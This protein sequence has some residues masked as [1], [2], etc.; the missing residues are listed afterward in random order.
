M[1]RRTLLA[2]LGLF[3]A[4]PGAHAQAQAPSIVV[5]IDLR[6]EMAAGR[7]DPM[8]DSVGLRGA[9][10][11][12]SWQRTLPAAAVPGSPGWY[13]LS[14]RLD[15]APAQP[16][17]YKFKIDRPDAA[18]DDGWENGRNRVFVVGA[19]PV[20]IERAFGTDPGA[21]P[22]QRTGTIERIAPRPSGFVAPREVQVWLPPG[23]G[24]DTARRYPV[25]YLHDG[26]NVFDHEAAGAEW[27]VDEAAERGVKGG[28]LAPMIIVAV[29]STGARVL[30]YTPSAVS[31]GGRQQ[32]GGAALYARYLA[33]ELKPLI[34]T[35]YATRPGREHTAVG[36]SSLGGLV[37]MWLLLHHAGTF[38]AGLVV[39]PSVWW[40]GGAILREVA[41]FARG[42]APR[43]W[44]DMGGRE[45][46]PAVQGAR[47]LRD[48]LVQRGWPAQYTEAPGEGHDEAAW[49][50]RVPAMLRF[51][52]PVG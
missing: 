11:P 39:S 36:G 9:V 33:E 20:R 12:L 13:E 29:A 25:L 3:G 45:G 46:G 35:R 49:A 5:R 48:A 15:S 18:P 22:P 23:Y 37:S 44:L 28:E 34:D 17:A 38:G 51:L 26:Q 27:Q 16:V 50:R 43:I 52:Y 7:F 30:D 4:S 21:P 14:L 31:L 10:P 42:P 8:R 1:L 40:G 47:D 32:G 2:A 6:A 41:A 19:T 24:S